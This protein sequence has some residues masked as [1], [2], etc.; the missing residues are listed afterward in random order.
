MGINNV[1]TMRMRHYFQPHPNPYPYL[2][3]YVC[4][5]HFKRQLVKPWLLTQRSKP[6]GKAQHI[7]IGQQPLGLLDT[8]TMLQDA[9]SLADEK[10]AGCH[11][12]GYVGGYTT[13]SN[14]GGGWV[15]LLRIHG[16]CVGGERTVGS[17][18]TIQ[19]GYDD[20][21]LWTWNTNSYATNNYRKNSYTT[22]N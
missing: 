10:D 4:N 9:N 13:I 5:T 7:V 21:Y 1:C 19:Y 14:L 22:N 11:G 3:S 20:A 2:A 17:V 8:P 6:C 15:R 18:Y 12:G 16:V